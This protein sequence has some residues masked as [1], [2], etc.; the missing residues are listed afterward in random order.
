MYVQN[1]GILVLSRERH[2]EVS[3]QKNV[4]ERSWKLS[5]SQVVQSQQL[6]P[7]ASCFRRSFYFEQFWYSPVWSP[8]SLHLNC[9]KKVICIECGMCL[10]DF[11]IWTMA[12]SLL[13]KRIMNLWRNLSK[14]VQRQLN[15]GPQTY[16]MLDISQQGEYSFW[17]LPICSRKTLV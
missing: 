2:W 3:T 14:R 5:H 15:R 1:F 12:L 7:S 6:L 16:S 4:C 10:V 9:E 8:G 11:K 17:M 13:N